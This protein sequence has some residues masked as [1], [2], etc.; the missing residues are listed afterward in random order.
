VITDVDQ[1]KLDFAAKFVPG[2][3]TYRVDTTKTPE[4]NSEQIRALFGCGPRNLE[5]MIPSETEFNAPPTVL[6]CTGVESSII[7]AAYSCQR[8]GLVM[9]V[10]VGRSTIHN[11][12]FMHLSLGE[13]DLRFINRYSDTWP[14]GINALSNHQVMNLDAMV[15]H[16]FPLEQAIEAM[17]A[18]ANPAIPT[19]KVQIVDNTEI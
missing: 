9:V 16:T 3:L 6:E 10:G 18:C 1:A 5:K 12:P 15:T 2:T 4:Q 11:V 14:A 8:N 13:I 7:T 17:E 19:V